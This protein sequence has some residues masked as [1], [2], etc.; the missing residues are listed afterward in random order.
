LCLQSRSSNA[1][2]T[3]S[4]L[5][6]FWKWY[7]MNYFPRLVLNYNP[8]D[9]SLPSSEDYRHEPLALSLFFYFWQSILKQFSVII[10]LH[11]FNLQHAFL[12]LGIFSNNVY[13]RFCKKAN[14]YYILKFLEFSQNI[15]KLVCFNWVQTQLLWLLSL[16]T[17]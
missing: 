16:C 10:S 4:L 2:A 11:P 9:L 6:L 12:N 13:I 3:S 17:L 5:S 8:L 15:F 7:L 14:T 1:W